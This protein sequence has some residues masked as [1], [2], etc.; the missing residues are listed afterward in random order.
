[1]SDSTTVP[2]RVRVFSTTHC[3]WCRR[4]E[5]LLDRNDIPFEVI[6]VTADPAARAALVAESGGWHTVPVIFID[7]RPI[8]GYQELARMMA[9]GALNHLKIGDAASRPS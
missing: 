2:H 1:M 6:D 4:A 5:D 7:D 9:T 8:G 3:G